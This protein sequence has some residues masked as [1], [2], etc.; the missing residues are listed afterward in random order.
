MISKSRTFIV[1]ELAQTHEGSLELAKL[2]VKA[3][4]IAKA[5]AV[6]VQV[7]MAEELAVPSYKHYKLFKQLEWPEK[8]WKNLINFAHACGIEFFADVFGNDSLA[9]LTCNG[10]DGLK[11]HGTDMRNTRLLKGI[12]DVDLPLLLSVGG[13]TIE[14]TRTALSIITHKER[15]SPIVLM[16]GFQSYPTLAE[17]IHLNRMRYFKDQLGLPVGFADHIGG[18]HRLNFA[19]CAAAIGMGAVVIEK[20]LTIS[21]ELKMEDYESALSPEGFVEFVAQVR[22]LDGA[23]GPYSEEMFPVEADYR[24]DTRKHVVATV[25]LNARQTIKES[26]I[27][28]RRAVSDHAPSDL[29]QVVGKKADRDYEVNEIILAENL[30]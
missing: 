5:D 7:F 24:K 27:T 14:E 19:L 30:L 12:A 4:A 8:S 25:H 29:S 1:C 21:R 18:N 10:I 26:D 9:M 2:L 15:K 13:G 20:H 23:L 6:K 28:L 17:H 22:E 11:I 16:H 3:A